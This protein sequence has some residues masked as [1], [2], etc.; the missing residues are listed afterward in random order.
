[1]HPLLPFGVAVVD[2]ASMEPTLQ[3]GDRVLVGYR[4]PPRPG[5]LLVVEV[6]PGRYLVKRAIR[7]DDDGWWVERDN[8]RAGSDSWTFGAVPDNQVRGRVVGRLW[9]SPSRL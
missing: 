5:R 4:L 8:P 7:R 6:A 2:G 1:V 9:P 3:T